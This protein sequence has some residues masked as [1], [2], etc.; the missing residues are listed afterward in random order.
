MIGA[1][2]VGRALGRRLREQSWKSPAVITRSEV[3]ARRAAR[4]FGGGSA[5]TELSQEAAVR[6]FISLGMKRREV[7]NALL[8]LTRQVLDNLE[9]FGPHV[10]WTGPLARGDYGVVAAHENAPQ[11][12]PVEYLDVYRAVNRLAVR[13]L[14]RDEEAAIDE[15]A[16]VSLKSSSQSQVRGTTA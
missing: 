4:S 6:M 11:S 15:L 16:K 7:L 10:A 2:R 13:I 3:T 8:P 12:A 5:H 14:A 1:E 9:P